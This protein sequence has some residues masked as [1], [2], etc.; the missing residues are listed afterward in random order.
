MSIVKIKWSNIKR[1]SLIL[2]ILIPI[3]LVSISCVNSIEIID[4]FRS[5]NTIVIDGKWTSMDE[6]NGSSEESLI[7]NK[8]SGSAYLRTLNDD[9]FFY[10]LVD[11]VTYDNLK[12]GDSCMVVFDTK[13]DGG[14]SFKSDDLAVLIRWNTPTEIYPAIQ[15]GG[16]INDWEFLPSDI[17]V[18]SSLDSENNPYS[19]DPHLIFEFKIP[20]NNFDIS[21]DKIGF[22][23][24]LICDNENISA[25]FPLLQ[26][27]HQPKNWNDLI[28][29]NQSIQILNDAETALDEAIEAIQ[30]AE[31]EGRTEDLTN[32]KSL[33]NQAEDNMEIHDYINV[34]SYANQ[35][36]IVA[37]EA[38]IPSEPTENEDSTP[39][40]EFI[41][42]ISVICL[43]LFLKRRT[44]F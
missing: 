3:F 8:G 27:S 10:A 20:K 41:I 19:T 24:I 32:A 14:S 4:S 43:V 33:K 22:I 34:I 31:L 2:I 30:K 39:G 36:T 38:T 15:W 29:F 23:C 7:F 16:W 28:L 5:I 21:S 26:T 9:E 17:H 37:N 40:F 35:A 18:Q 1:V 13:N 6:W 25:G 12:T 44:G 11:F 42:I